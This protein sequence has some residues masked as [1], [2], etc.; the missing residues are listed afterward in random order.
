MIILRAQKTVTQICLNSN[1]IYNKWVRM[2][3]LESKVLTSDTWS[4]HS[5]NP[6]LQQKGHSE[7]GESVTWQNA[8]LLARWRIGEVMRPSEPSLRSDA[9]ISLTLVFKSIAKNVV[10]HHSWNL[11][12]HGF[13]G[14]SLFSFSFSFILHIF[15]FLNLYEITL[16]TTSANFT[17][18]LNLCTTS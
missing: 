7:L 17:R 5:A 9:R 16:V 4:H 1:K 8:S 13:P 11:R 10:S 18:F 15:V 3:S 12:Q 2:T 6:S 14:F